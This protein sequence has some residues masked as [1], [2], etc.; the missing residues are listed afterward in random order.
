MEA[1]GERLAGELSALSG[2]AGQYPAHVA[3]DTE[4]VI[5]ESA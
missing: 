4:L 2:P 3:L 5:R 1:M